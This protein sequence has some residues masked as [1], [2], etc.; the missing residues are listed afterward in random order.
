[1][2][3]RNFTLKKLIHKQKRVVPSKLC[4]YIVSE[5]KKEHWDIHSWYQSDKDLFLS[6]K[7]NEPK[8]MSSTQQ[9]QNLLTPHINK[10]VVEYDKMFSFSKC[11]RAKHVVKKLSKVRF[12]KYECGDLMRQHIDHIQSL[13]DGNEKGIPVLSIIVSLNDEY[14]GG[15]LYFWENYNVKMSKGD[16]LIFPSSFLFPHGVKKIISGVRYSA[17]CWGW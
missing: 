5:I 17:V 8:V 4:D 3:D 13:F 9:L 14:S 11:E 6:E 1:M 16:I 7:N 12:N 2:I 10:C 15:E